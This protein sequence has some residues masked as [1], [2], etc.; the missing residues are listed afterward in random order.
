[1]ITKAPVS[2]RHYD[3]LFDYE[4]KKGDIVLVWYG[5]A[6]VPR[7]LDVFEFTGEDFVNGDKSLLEIWRDTHIVSWEKIAV[8]TDPEQT[9]DD[10]DNSEFKLSVG[11]YITVEDQ[12]E[13]EKKVGP[14]N[15]IPWLGAGAF[16]LI[17]PDGTVLEEDKG[18]RSHVYGPKCNGLWSELDEDLDRRE[19]FTSF[20]GFVKEFYVV[21]DAEERQRIKEFTQ[22]AD[23]LEI[24]KRKEIFVLATRI[25]L[26]GSDEEDNR[27]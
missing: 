10:D 11:D 22:R 27:A 1:M 15:R 16:M 24:V 5:N 12:H 2:L 23:W 17:F 19:D 7:Q 14:I 26:T 8:E 18:I 9:E 25:A 13:W 21:W 6:E 20:N 4:W 3:C